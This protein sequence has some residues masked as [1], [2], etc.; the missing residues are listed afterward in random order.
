[1]TGTTSSSA[2]PRR[3]VSAAVLVLVPLVT[4][5]SC[6]LLAPSDAEL[7]GGIGAGNASAGL[8]AGGESAGVSGRGSGGSAKDPSGG[9]AVGGAHAG[10]DRGGTDNDSA[11]AGAPAGADGGASTCGDGLCP[12]A[13]GKHRCGSSC[14]PDEATTSCGSS[15]IPCPVPKNGIATCLQGRCGI[16]CDVGFTPCGASCVDITSDADHCGGCD[17]QNQCG[18]DTTCVDGQCVSSSGC[19]DGSR[20]GFNPISAFPEIAGCKANWSFASLRAAKTSAACGN[21]LGECAVPADACGEGWHVCAAPPYGPTDVSSRVTA[22]QCLAQPGSYALAVGDQSCEPCSTTG[23]GAACC[24]NECVQQEGN[25]VFAGKTAW[26]GVIDGYKNVC[27]KMEAHYAS[28][29]VAC[30]RD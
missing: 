2:R 21:S 23:D 14:E 11:D 8:G 30:C 12:C 9:A 26:I 15:C 19:S 13:P 1:M 28:M 5:G 10:D 20:E 22:E 3:R 24:G 16:D 25:C 18:A 7:M 27:G 6:S 29:G 17:P 4:L